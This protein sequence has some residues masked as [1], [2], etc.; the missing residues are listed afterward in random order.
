MSDSASTRSLLL[1]GAA[2]VLV[3]G[4]GGG[5][6]F[7]VM[8]PSS[9][10]RVQSALP[11]LPPLADAVPTLSDKLASAYQRVRTQG[12]T[13]SLADY[14]RLLHANGFAEAA[15]QTWRLL[16][17][18]DAMEGR[19]SYYLAHLYRDIGD[20]EE[21]TALLRTTADIAPDYSPAWL[22][23]GDLALKSGQFAAAKNYYD[24]RLQ[25]VPGDPYARLGLARIDFQ[26]D[27]REETIAALVELVADHPRFAS[28]HNLL[29]RLYR[30]QGN[31]DLAED[32][33]W[34]GYKSGRFTTAEDP[35]M[36]E[37]N[38]WC[39]TP[40]KLF[41]IGMVDF[42]TERGDRGR[43]EYERAVRVDPQDPGNHELLGDYYRKLNEPDLAR[44][45]LRASISL[46]ETQGSVP[47]LLSFINLAAI[48]REQQRFEVSRR[49]ADAGIVVHP[50]SPELRVESGLTRQ[51]MGRMKEAEAAF[52]HALELSP[53]DTAAHFHLGEMRLREDRI[54][55]A[56]ASFKA[57]LVQQPTFAPAL[58]YLIQY[59]LS[60]GQLAEAG[61]YCDTLLKAYWG[62]PEVRQLVAILHLRRGRAELSAGALK[63]AIAQFQRGFHLNPNDVDLAFELGTLQLAQA[64]PQAAIA[65]L[66]VF[67]E[68]RPTDPRAHLFLAQAYL[69]DGRTRRAQSLLENGLVLAE[70]SGQTGTA[71]NIREMLNA[72]RR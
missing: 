65:P 7:M 11:A 36:R 39:F 48:E 40:E 61:S 70:E 14:G 26:L 5:I 51:A 22:Q 13:A 18:E 66:E 23:L 19:W 29:S 28:A 17:R 55:E 71:A 46:A 64:N 3:A 63:A 15:M 57:A 9:T 34:A 35:W 59:T 20:I 56:M 8:A 1:T 33:R 52:Q 72:I 12:D 27:R 60:T 31:A 47:P 16:M 43:S 54:E 37:L 25:L 44:E 21:T 62:D 32:H 45:S 69:M 2:T 42:Q 10:E 50:N 68:Q 58:R 41:V 67:L 53:N 24:Q 6:T 38:A 30:E 4:I 49:V